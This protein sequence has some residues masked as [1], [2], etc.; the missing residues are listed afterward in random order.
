MTQQRKADLLLVLTTFI[1]AC[2]WIFSREAITGM[3]VFAFLGLRFLFAS[4]CLLPFWG[5]QRISR[6]QWIPALI[7]G[8]WLA[9]NMCLWIYSV[10]TT[11]S[12]GEGAFIMSLSM[13]FVPLVAWGLMKIRPLSAYWECLPLAMIGLGLLSLHQ[14]ITFHPSQ[15][16]FLLTAIVQA[17]SFCYTSRCSRKVP[18]IPLTTVQLAC[19]GV[20]GLVLSLFL[21]QWS[22]P[23]SLPTGL[24]LLA[25]ILIATSLRFGLQLKGQK[26]ATPANA[27][28]IMILEPLLTVIA[29]AF[30]YG[31]HLPVQQIIGGLLILVAQFFYRWRTLVR[32]AVEGRS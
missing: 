18:L 8:L 20:S 5:G 4:M 26:Y 21:E 10:S 24:W 28:I 16:W 6:R 22:Q 23:F 13:L 14:P 17:V 7:S 19:T 32:P 3:P 2:G 25:S 31:E 15:G 1:A 11:P 9:L 12:L 27:A 29:A 30:W